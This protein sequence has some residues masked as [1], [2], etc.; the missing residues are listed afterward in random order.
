MNIMYILKVLPFVRTASA[1]ASLV[2]ARRLETVE[3]AAQVRQAK[4]IL[5][6]EFTTLVGEAPPS[7]L[8]K[9]TLPTF[10]SKLG[11]KATQLVPK[12]E[13]GSADPA[14]EGVVS[15][16]M[17]LIEKTVTDD[18][19]TGLTLK[20]AFVAILGD[21]QVEVDGVMVGAAEVSASFD[22]ITRAL[23]PEWL[24][25]AKQY[26]GVD[27]GEIVEELSSEGEAQSND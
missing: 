25:S 1:A 19:D 21:M 23:P 4:A 17:G 6:R 11:H 3:T 26:T 27:V 15:R 10:L 8:N 24:G 2:R 16:M 20:D 14:V 22:V 7:E 5:E 13:D 9:E 18:S 12:L